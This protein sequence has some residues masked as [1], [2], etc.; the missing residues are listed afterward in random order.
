MALFLSTFTNKVDKKGRVSVPSPFRAALVGQN[1][2]GLVAF[3]S[4]RLPA[5]E[6]LDMARMEQFSESTDSLDLFSEEHEDITATIFA[7]AVQL[8]FDGEGRIVLPANLVEH[9]GI[10]ET[11]TFVG[12]G[13]TFQIWEPERFQEFQDKARQRAREQGLTLRLKPGQDGGQ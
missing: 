9:A 7:D 11:A 10:S 5:I 8:P 2:N 4:Y 13:R 6:G 1:F 3:R 12:R